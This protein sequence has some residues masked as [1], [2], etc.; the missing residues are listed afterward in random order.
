MTYRYGTPKSSRVVRSY[1]RGYLE[2]HESEYAS[3]PVLHVAGEPEA[4]GRQYGALVGD[5]MAHLRDMALGLYGAAGIPPEISGA[6]LDG[7]WERL[8]PHVADEYLVEMEAMA[9]GAREAGCDLTTLDMHRLLA[10]TNADLYRREARFLEFLDDDTREAL[11]RMMQPDALPPTASCTMFAAWGDRTADGRLF[12][13]RNLDWVSRTGMHEQRLVTVY[14]PEGKCAFATMDYAGT[15]GALAGMNDH[16]VTVSEVGAFSVRE[17][18]DGVPWVL[19]ARRVLEDATCL[20]GAVHIATTAKHTLGYNYLLAHG[21]PS[22]FGSSAF[23]PGAAAIET[24]FVACEVFRDDDPE[25]REATWTDAEGHARVYGLALPEWVCRA[26]T[27]FGRTTRALQATDNGPGAPENDGNPFIEEEG[28]SYIDCHKPMHDMVRAYETGSEYV[29]P[30]RG[31]KVIEAG[32]PRNIDVPEALNIAGTV[33]HNREKLH[34]S[35]WDVMSIVY[36]ATG[37]RFWA[38]YESQDADGNWTNAPDSGYLEF[39]LGDLLD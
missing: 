4:M 8:E 10:V 21:D 9:A 12:S 30:V 33:A 17:E 23:A 34:L 16:G 28:N 35:D 24:N 20:D 7:I 39:D 36:D 22:K 32:E 11:V 38:A 3:I 5:K 26:D 6:I 15:P 13:C 27:A 37:L 18:V 29:F 19:M 31:E 1:D 2:M 25:E 14:Q